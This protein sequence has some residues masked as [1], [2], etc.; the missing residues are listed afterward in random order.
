MGELFSKVEA[1]APGSPMR[2]TLESTLELVDVWKAPPLPVVCVAATGV[3]TWL[4]T[5]DGP[6]KA[7]ASS[8]TSDS[9]DEKTHASKDSP[10]LASSAVSAGQAESCSCSG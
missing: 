3:P 6:G 7:H 2:E 5:M 1:F 9:C 10:C 4:S 8:C